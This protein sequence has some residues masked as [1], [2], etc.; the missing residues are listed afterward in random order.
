MNKALLTNQ[1]DFIK[2][3]PPGETCDFTEEGAGVLRTF[4][5]TREKLPNLNQTESA[6][7]QKIKRLL[8]H[9]EN[10]CKVAPPP[11][12]NDQRSQLVLRTA[13]DKVLQEDFSKLSS[14]EAA[15]LRGTYASLSARSSSGSSDRLQALLAKVI[16]R[17]DE[18]RPDR[19][20]TTTVFND[21]N[22]VIENDEG[23]VFANKINAEKDFGDI[24]KK[25]YKILEGIE[26]NLNVRQFEFEG[27][28][29]IAGDVPKDVLL[30]ITKGCLQVNGFVSGNVVV[31]GDVEING[32]I[33]G[34]V[35]ISLDGS[36][37]LDRCLMGTRLIALKGN[38]YCKHLEAPETAFAWDTLQVDGAVL[39][40]KVFGGKIEISGKAVSA[41]FH[42]T[43]QINVARAETGTRGPCSIFLNPTLTCE[44]YGRYMDQSY[45]DKQ[46]RV[47]E[48]SQQ[49]ALAEQLD[50]YTHTMIH[51]AYRTALF[52][53]LGGVDSASS[54]MNL[55]GMQLKAIYLE[56]VVA[57]SES[58][59]GYYR[60]ETEDSKELDVE[61]F[62]EF[63]RETQETFK[64]IAGDI[65]SLPEEFGSTHRRYL[66]DRCDEFRA[67]S[68][69]LSSI[70][71][72]EEIKIA[73]TTVFT[74][75]LSSWRG[76]LGEAK[77]DTHDLIQQFGLPEETL[78][79]I[80]HSPESLDD[81]LDETIEGI[82]QKNEFQKVQRAK[83]PLI[84][85]L[86]QSAD[87][88]A[89][90]I[91]VSHTKILE[92]RKEIK[93][94]K[95]ELRDESVVLYDDT[96]T[97]SC[98]FSAGFCGDGTVISSSRSQRTGRDT[99]LAKTIVLESTIEEQ[100]EFERMDN[101]VQR[102]T[103]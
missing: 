55:Q 78:Y 86:R 49:I 96:N 47:S 97:G 58:I 46:R 2:S 85:L 38:V 42:S 14:D 74:K 44:D 70:T 41:E 80:E 24:S 89:R 72:P 84:R 10:T 53:L 75:T 29:L 71:E 43:G 31:D 82:F 5:D 88:Y 77:R 1:L 101:F 12:T 34:G 25:S 102:K 60:S 98:S 18:V 35:A 59:N 32:N 69:K 79:K 4:V 13:I 22:L 52:Y 73:I 56:Q 19:T 21:E 11:G 63:I 87:R 67:F 93:E 83:S 81:M 7:H 9:W 16:Q 68:R 27:N 23:V 45:A 64:L 65:E 62:Q 8:A 94:I 76:V 100:V 28:T 3:L 15:L 26:V 17:L 103:A 40:G 30:K 37:R 66:L 61:A 48:L 6:L 39:S 54:A 92:F 90:N 50:Q 51:N 91:E 57:L 99:N 36:I 33:Q 20:N 95:D